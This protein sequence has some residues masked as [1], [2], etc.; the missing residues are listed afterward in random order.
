VSQEVKDTWALP[1]WDYSR[2]GQDD[3]WRT[4]PTALRSPTRDDGSPNPLFTARRNTTPG[5]NMNA[6]DP[7]DDLFVSPRALN[8]Q[9]FARAPIPGGTNGFGGPVTGW[10]HDPG[11]AGRLEI[12]PHGDVHTNV[13]GP[14]GLM[15]SFAGAPLDPAFWLHHAN[16][17]RLW[18]VWL[19]QDDVPRQ[20]PTDPG[21]LDFPFA[22]R[23]A[24]GTPHRH[25][26]RH[27]RGQ[28]G[29]GLI[30]GA[31]RAGDTAPHPRQERVSSQR[32]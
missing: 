28:R 24:T 5:L 12:T 4:L 11:P 17:D 31:D 20:N 1:Y 8:K 10:H 30:G 7:L 26:Q 13:G 14:G 2:G 18:V 19:N 6:G 29:G 3:Q 32:R 9:V 23:D 16:I 21:W 15:T 27:A 25:R 22:F